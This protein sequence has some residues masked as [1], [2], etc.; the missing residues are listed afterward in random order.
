MELAKNI[1]LFSYII[2][3]PFSFHGNAF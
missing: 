2:I 1:E 3:K